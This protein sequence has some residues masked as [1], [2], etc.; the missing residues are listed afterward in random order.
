LLGAAARTA[1][2]AGTATAV[3]GG[4]RRHQDARAEDRAEQEHYEQQQQD[5]AMQAQMQQYA[6]QAAP[7]TVDVAAKIKELADLRAAG[8]LTE[9]EFAA[10]KAKL[11]A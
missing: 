7:G 5:A 4:V 3:A 9:E 1:V 6:Q 2:V 11:L 8:A 10:A